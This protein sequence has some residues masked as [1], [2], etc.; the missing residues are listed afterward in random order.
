MEIEE[1]GISFV[2]TKY[3]DEDDD[4]DEDDDYSHY[5]YY[6]SKKILGKLY[7]AI[8]ERQIFEDITNRARINTIQASDAVQVVWGFVMTTCKL[9]QFEHLLPWAADLREEYVPFLLYMV[10]P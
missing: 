2:K 3:R 8:D 7:R 10:A 5:R 4:A 6:E 1:K 9:I